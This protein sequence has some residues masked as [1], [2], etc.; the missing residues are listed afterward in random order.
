[1][2]DIVKYIKDH[3]TVDRRDSFHDFGE[4]IKIEFTI[5]II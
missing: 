2:P 1:M 5:R 3:H 4:L